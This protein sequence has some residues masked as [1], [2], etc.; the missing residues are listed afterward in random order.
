MLFAHDY[1]IEDFGNSPESAINAT[2]PSGGGQTGA[3]QLGQVARIDSVS[4][5]LSHSRRADLIF[6]LDAPAGASS[7]AASFSFIAGAGNAAGSDLGDGGSDLL[8]LA[9]Y[10]FTESASP[11]LASVGTNPTPG[12]VYRV[13]QGEWLSAP[14]GGMGAGDLGISAGGIFSP[15]TLAQWAGSR[16]V[17]HSS[18]SLPP[19]PCSQVSAPLPELRFGAAPL[20]PQTGSPPTLAPAGRSDKGD[21]AKSQ[22]RRLPVQ[23]GAGRWHGRPFSAGGRLPVQARA[24]QPFPRACPFYSPSPRLRASPDKASADRLFLTQSRS[25]SK[26]LPASR[27]D[28]R[29]ARGKGSNAKYKDWTTLLS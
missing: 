5:E 1:D 9:T 22:H 19:S 6:Q 28:G 26:S 10:T 17:A 24:G 4:I 14:P 7:G 29:Q 12:G 23:A 3:F 11:T 8:G 21:R 25:L 20:P 15:V 27:R 18:R 13:A 16:C 2:L